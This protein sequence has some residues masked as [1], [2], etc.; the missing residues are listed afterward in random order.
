MVERGDEIGAI[1]VSAEVADWSREKPRQFWDPSRKL[2]L[3]I[4]RYQHWHNKKGIVAACTCKWF[5]LRHRFWS[6]VTGAEIPLDCR[7]GGG[8]LIN[9]PNGIVIDSEATIGVNCL[10]FQQVTIGNKALRGAVPEVAG[11]VDVGAGAKVMGSIK[12]G[13]HAKIAANSLVIT[14]VPAGATAI[15]VP[16]RILPGTDRGNMET[17]NSSV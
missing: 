7:I 13:A 4:R 5:V 2:L 12:I 1:T 10:I 16:A 9:H 14:D 8:L 11:H 15:G 17:P 3:A 6:I